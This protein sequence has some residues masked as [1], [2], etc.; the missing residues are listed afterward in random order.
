MVLQIYYL[1]P[2]TIYH[3]VSMDQLSVEIVDVRHL[4]R[5]CG[6]F[7]T[8]FM[9][10]FLYFTTH[11]LI[12]FVELCVHIAHLSIF[13]LYLVNLFTFWHLLFH[14]SVFPLIAF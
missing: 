4:V 11:L 1:I 2:H 10:H 5:Q 12:F 9:K 8:I 13:C 7:L 6:C 14:P 3:L